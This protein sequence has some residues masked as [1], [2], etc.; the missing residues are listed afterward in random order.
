VNLELV[1]TEP[2]DDVTAA[3][4]KISVI[5]NY[6]GL[7]FT[8]P[9]SASVF[10]ERLRVKR[11]GY[12]PKI[13]ALGERARS[14]LERFGFAVKHVK[15]ANTA[16]DLIAGFETSEFSGKRFLYVRGEASLRAI[17]E[18]LGKIADVD[19]ATV[20][21]TMPV[22]P[23]PE[24]LSSIGGRLQNGEFEAVCF[25]SPSGVERF[26]K[27]FPI[28]KANCIRAAAI[29]ETTAAS[30]KAAGFQKVFVSTT[31]NA[32]QFAREFAEHIKNI[33]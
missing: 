6:D 10:G 19:E 30:A 2:L 16:A 21:R 29:G 17:P 23:S 27:L 28:V 9:V 5:E 25:F 7:F 1:R 14:V 8:S 22:E 12:A 3:D 15:N 11:P 33:E 26:E 18:L 32:E 13:Y 4:Q 24:I 31:A 20:Y